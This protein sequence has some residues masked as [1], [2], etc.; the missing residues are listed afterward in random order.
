MSKGK[1]IALGVIVFLVAI[2][3]VLVIVVPLLI[4]LNRYRPQVIAHIQEETGKPAE[5]GKIQL[6]LFPSVSIRV[7]GFALG[8][9]PGFPKGYLVKA[10]RIYA[11]VDARALLDRRVV[12]Q[13]LELDRPVIRLLSDARGKW[14]FESPPKTGKE[15]KSAANDPSAF[16]LGVIPKA[17][18][19]DGD[20]A[21]TNLL[22]SG[23]PGPNFFEGNGISINLED[24]DLNAFASESASS[25]IPRSDP[26]RNSA[27]TIWGPA[28]VY[29]APAA[30]RPAAQGTLRADSLSFGTLKATSVKTKIR[31]FPKQIYFDDL[32]F[33][34]YGGR[35]S[36]NLSCDF[37]GA[38]PRYATN[39]RLS[40]VDVASLLEALPGAR[41]KM[42]GKLD[43]NMKLNG[44]VVHSPDPLAGM[45]GTG[46]VSVKDGQLPSLQLNKNLMMLARLSSLGPGSGDPSSFKSMSSD[47]NIA[48]GKIASNKVAIVGNGVDV[49]GAGVMAIAGEGSLAYD[50]TAKLAA[51]Q[52][53]LTA[54][55]GGLSGATYADSKLTF[56]FTIGG[57]FQN[58]Q[59]KVKSL[60]S[61]Q[62]MTGLQGLLGGGQQA[63]TQQGQTGQQSP[64][65]LVQG[66]GGLFK[67]K[68]TTQQPQPK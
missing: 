40:G 66:L 54:L 30:A 36:G 45:R 22:A 44:V 50:G 56:P 32:T 38:S 29:A 20:I 37:G 68:Q 8:N 4:D 53:P 49:D 31:L 13:S 63:G 12:I 60:G 61:K 9:P 34:F 41:G 17:S 24:V 52:N 19:K 6:T 1:K 67:K 51:A 28:L 59:F 39:A 18:I 11:V 25:V 43:G 57:T 7:D 3:A 46:Q 55:L 2:V 23:R 48:D 65:N 58:P 27:S 14:N 33:D 47:L 21:G 62:Q 10:E 64:A 16:T 15:V 35:A 26:T 5:I 42:T